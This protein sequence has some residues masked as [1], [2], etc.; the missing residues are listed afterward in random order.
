MSVRSRKLLWVLFLIAVAA[1]STSRIAKGQSGHVLDGIGPV[2]QSMGGATTALPL[3]AIGSIHRNPAAILGLPSSEIALG[4]GAFSPSVDLSSTIPGVGSGSTGSDGDIAPLPCMGFVQ[5]TEDEIWAFGFGAFAVAGFGVDFP[6]NPANP[7]NSSDFF[8]GIY[9]SFQM[10]QI[11]TPIACQLSDR[12]S[13]GVAPNFNWASLG[14]TPFSAAA[15]DLTPSPVYP[16]GAREDG[17]W[18]LGFQVGAYLHDPGSNWRLALAY[19]SPQWFQDFKI[20]SRD[21]SGNPRQLEYGMDYPAI[22]SL[23]IAYSGFKRL[24]LSCD[25][26]YID[27]EHTEGFQSAQFGSDMSVSGFGWKN[28]FVYAVG[29]QYHLSDRVQVRMG[30]A[31]NDSP[32]SSDTIFFNLAAPAIV[33]HH[34]SAGFSWESPWKWVLSFAYHAGFENTLT[35]PIQLPVPAGS[36]VGASLSTHTMLAAISKRF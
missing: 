16:D 12:I 29:A 20:N 15:P 31:F 2:D 33:Q 17:T 25:V 14:A 5:Q 11:A 30:Y 22:V 36:T 9:T 3:D 10:L 6:D 4:M 27:Y 32:I 23:G 28:I 18:G 7:I 19:S 26:R 34:L 21:P 13:V 8:G 1:F 24:D 35:G